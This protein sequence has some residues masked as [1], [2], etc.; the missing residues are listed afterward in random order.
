MKLVRGL[1]ADVEAGTFADPAR[2]TTVVKA[3]VAALKA[4]Y[5]GK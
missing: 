3:K 4:K 2:F 5:E 1:T